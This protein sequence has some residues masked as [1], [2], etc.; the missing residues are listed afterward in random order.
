M[1][2]ND[3]PTKISLTSRDYTSLRDEILNKIPIITK[4]QWSNLNSSD[5]GIALVELLASMVD[6]LYYYQDAISTELYLPSANQRLSLMKLLRVFGYEISV[7]SAAKG[8]VSLAIATAGQTGTIQFPIALDTF[9]NVQFSAQTASG[10]TIY[11][12]LSP[13][14][15]LGT[16][17]GSYR[18][19]SVQE[20]ITVPVIEGVRVA[21]NLTTFTSDGTQNQRFVI[22]QPNVDIKQILVTINN[23]IWTRV[24]SFFNTTSTSPVY[25]VEYSDQLIPVIIF[26]DGQFGMIPI[27]GTTI[28]VNA[29]TSIGTNG[30]VGAGAINKILTTITD[31]SGIQT[32]QLSV[33]NSAPV[34]GGAGIE[35]LTSAKENA[36]GNLITNG[37]L[38]TKDDFL[39]ILSGVP[40][41]D[42]LTVW[43]ENE[44]GYP[45]YSLMNRIQI[46]FYSTTSWDF[47]DINHVNKYNAIMTQLTNIVQNLIPVTTR[48]TFVRPKL[49]D[50]YLTL[51][52]GIDTRNYDPQLLT[53]QVRTAIKNFYSINNVSFGQVINISTLSQVCNTVPGVLWSQITRLHTIPVPTTVLDAGPPQIMY[54]DPATIPPS[55]LYLNVNEL[56]VFFGSAYVINPAMVAP[57]PPYI[58]ISNFPS[59]YDL[60]V[61]NTVSVPE[62][63]SIGKVG[64]FNVKVMN[65]DGQEDTMS[66]KLT[67]IPNTQAEHITITYVDSTKN[68]QIK[69]GYL[70]SPKV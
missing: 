70:N 65:P 27:Y 1:A 60:T 58:K 26:G 7:I 50:I 24:G 35:S 3:L 20:K 10:A 52:L 15:A 18:I 44:Q 14:E 67:I 42:K 30:T 11:T 22:N 48:F 68:Q 49:V 12:M 46:C 45:D 34:V 5:P 13:S 4:G 29:F 37:R 32:I 66:N 56:P 9:N 63:V 54:P 47:N 64:T 57:T 61:K 17:V 55:D 23:S 2:L 19:N 25:K 8:N 21:S 43:G 59:I 53:S 33:S 40:N 16:P 28:V 39:T 38:M 41:V 31:S 36:I 62:I 6:N 69:T 51:S